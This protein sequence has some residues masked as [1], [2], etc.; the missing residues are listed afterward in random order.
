MVFSRNP[1]KVKDKFI[2]HNPSENLDNKII[3]MCLNM[4]VEISRSSES[5]VTNVTTVRFLPGV[6]SC[7]Y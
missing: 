3:C 5:L 2:F 6:D 7:V 1:L 4:F